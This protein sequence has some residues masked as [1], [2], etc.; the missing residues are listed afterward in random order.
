[1]SFNWRSSMP[2]RSAGG[3]CSSCGGASAEAGGVGDFWCSFTVIPSHKNHWGS[4]LAL[5]GGQGSS[6]EAGGTVPAVLSAP[7]PSAVSATSA[8][9]TASFA[10]WRQA[11]QRGKTIVLSRFPGE[12]GGTSPGARHA[13]LGAHASQPEAGQGHEQLDSQRVPTFSPLGLGWRHVRTLGASI[14][15]HGQNGNMACV[16]W[17]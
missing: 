13:V 16:P 8:L 11:R 7:T 2:T 1:M 9:M 6:V 10:L 14:A 4:A 15:N 12:P 3:S 17:Q 5:P